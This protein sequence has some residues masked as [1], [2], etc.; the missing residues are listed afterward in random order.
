ME[1]A[2][3]YFHLLGKSLDGCR[4][5][6][7][8]GWRCYTIQRKP[9]IFFDEHTQNGMV[10]KLKKS[11]IDRAFVNYD[12]EIFNP[13]DKGKPMKNWIVI[14]SRFRHVWDDLLYSSYHYI[15]KEIENGK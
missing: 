11:E 6:N 7:M 4:S 14:S 12:G 10:F 15:L 13:G 8:F 1:N 3:E 9:F 5:G 2:E